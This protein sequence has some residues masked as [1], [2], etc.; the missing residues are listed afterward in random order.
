M[1]TDTTAYTSTQSA[2]A[3]NNTGTLAR[4]GY[5]F[6]GWNTLADGSGTSYA[7]GSG[8]IPMAG[9]NITLY[10]K[11]TATLTYNANSAT[12]GTVPTDTTAYTSTQ[13]ATTSNNTGTLARTGF[14]FAGWNTLANG[15]GTSYAAGSGSIPMA[16]GNITLYAKWTSNSTYDTWATLAGIP[17][18]QAGP[19]QTPQNDGVKNLTKFAFNM[20]AAKPDT[21]TLSVGGNGTSGLPGTAVVGGVLRLEFLRRKDNPGIT[22]TPQFSS[23]M[24]TSTWDDAVVT[25][26]PVFIDAIWERVVIDDPAALPGKRFGRVRVDQTP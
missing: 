10:A 4:T 16:G 25:N 9:G 22:Y 7:A 23:S 2:T 6:A 21:S 17:P 3:S 8:S 26:P 20:N 13:S 1:P 11:W 12:T 15:S 19:N 24:G 18:A 5:T 14:T